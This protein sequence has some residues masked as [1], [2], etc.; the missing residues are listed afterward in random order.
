MGW[1][2]FRLDVDGGRIFVKCYHQ[3]FYSVD[4]LF[5]GVSK[6][7]RGGIFKSSIVSLD[8][9]EYIHMSCSHD[10]HI[11]TVSLLLCSTV[12]TIP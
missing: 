6:T 9:L 12:C 10:I 5:T 1:L 8:F 11:F 4:L 2:R 7:A 3:W